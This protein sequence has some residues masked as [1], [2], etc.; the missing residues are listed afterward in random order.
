MLLHAYTEEMDAE[1]SSRSEVQGRTEHEVAWDKWD[2]VN[3][4][5]KSKS[6]IQETNK[7]KVG[8]MVREPLYVKLL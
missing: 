3:R 5:T 6:Q 4:N 2:P 7:R 1:S 8:G